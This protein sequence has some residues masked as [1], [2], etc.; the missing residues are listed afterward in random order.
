MSD[1]FEN[2]FKFRYGIRKR[3]EIRVPIDSRHRVTWNLQRHLGK[4]YQKTL[5]AGRSSRYIC[6]CLE[7]RE[8]GVIRK[9]EA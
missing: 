3:K 5:Q 1:Y 8:L 2:P 4:L 9:D 6:C 7:V